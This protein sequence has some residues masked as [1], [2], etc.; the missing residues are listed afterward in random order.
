[1]LKWDNMINS[2]LCNSIDKS[3]KHDNKY[4]KTK[5]N[6]IDCFSI[7]HWNS[8]YY[9]CPSLY[10]QRNQQYLCQRV[11]LIKHRCKPV[12]IICFQNLSLLFQNIKR[13][14]TLITSKPE[15]RVLTGVICPISYMYNTV[16]II[17]WTIKLV[18]L[19]KH[20]LGLI[21]CSLPNRPVAG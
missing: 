18:V 3:Q 10:D 16:A 7:F 14:S 13:A 4:R 12:D 17:V 20:F 8:V 21:F 15:I 19:H 9:I 5:C 2:V 1:M 6:N 11:Y